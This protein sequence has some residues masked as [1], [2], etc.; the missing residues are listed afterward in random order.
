MELTAQVGSAGA[1]RRVLLGVS[2][3]IAAV[4]APELV[5]RLRE[6]GWE[7]RCALTAAGAAF[8]TPLTLEV[9]SGHPVLR[10]EYLSATGSGEEIHIE[11]ARWA[12]VLVVAPATAHLLGRLSLGLA[13]DFLT[14]VALAFEGPVVLA[15]AMHSSMW[16]KES[17]QGHVARLRERGALFV[18]PV[19]GALASGEHGWGRMAEP[20]EI[21]GALAGLARSGPLAARTVLVTAGPTHEP[22]DPVRFL[23]NRSSGKMGYELAAAAARRGARVVL[24]S[25]PTA[26]ATPP[27]VERV[28]VTTAAEMAEAVD[29]HAPEADLV[30]AAAAVADFRP[31]EAAPGKL[32]KREGA[33]RLELEPTPDILERLAAR[34]PRAL[35]VGFAA[36]TSDVEAEARRKLERKG[37]DFIVANDVS[38][39]EIGFGSDDNEVLVLGRDGES[40]LIPRRSKRQVAEALLGLLEPRLAGQREGAATPR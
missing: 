40:E 8:T 3:G 7:V 12:D 25:G 30:L 15:P 35:L 20:E 28:D 6:Q 33:P 39:P 19:A 23:G 34:S 31:R 24:I 5:R 18:G 1:R 2:G 16:A 27:G 11:T 38:R 13:D 9:L 14:T 29:R 36:E 17:V 21:L 32:K 4:K 22:L 37:L 26:L 10:E